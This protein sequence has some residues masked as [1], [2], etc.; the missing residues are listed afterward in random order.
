[1][2]TGVAVAA[3]SAGGA[4]AQTATTQV[5]DNGTAVTEFV[6]TGSRIPE[7]NLTSV[8]PVSV[9]GSDQIQEAGVVRVEDVINQ[10]PQAFAG[11]GSNISNGASGTATVDL[12]GLGCGRTLVLI[13]G[14]RLMPGDP[15]VI[16]AD[17]NFIP[18][19]LIERVDVLTG[20]ASAVY[21][22]DAMA[23]V[24]NFIMRR[25]M[26]GI[27]IDAQVSEYVHTNGDSHIDGIV[28]AERA[29]SANPFEFNL[30]P[31][32]VEDGLAKD[33]TI[34]I[35]ANAPDNKGNVTAYASYRK[36]DPVLQGQRDYS[37]CT[38]GS[39]A[40][41]TCS[42]S[43]TTFPT[44]IGG[45]IVNPVTGNS[46]RAANSVTDVYNF[47]PTNYYQRPD[48]RF[49]IGSFAH[50]EIQ[51]WLTAYTDLM[52]M[53]DRST[54]QI[55]P[56]GYF[57][58]V[59]QINC[60]NP[61]LD[62]TLANSDPALAATLCTPA[63]IANG[64]VIS[65]II[66]RRDVEGG[67]RQTNLEHVQQR[68]VVGLKGDLN[69]VWSYDAYLQYGRTTVNSS[70]TGNFVTTREQNALLVHNVNGVPTCD[71]VVNGSDTKCVPINLFQTG[72]VTQAALNYLSAVS[73]ATGNLG[74]QLANV[75]VTGKLG[76][77]GLKSPWS[78]EGVGINFGAETRSEHLD[79]Q[80]DFLSQ[81]GLVD[82]NGAAALPVN[83][84]YNVNEL[85]AE[86]RVPLV[87]DAPFIKLLDFE[88]GY[89]YSQYSTGQQTSTYKL[90]G[91]F[92]PID[93]IRFRASYQR[94]ARAANVVELYA[95]Q[96]VVLDGTQDP[97][98]G[99]AAGAPNVAK[100]MTAFNYTQAQVLSIQANPANQY[101]G[102]TGGNPNLKPEVGNTFSVGAVVQPRMVP[103]LSVSV[104]YFNIKVNGF[105][106]GIGANLIL[107]T[108]VQTANP[109]F[110]SLVHRDTSQSVASGGFGSLWLSPNG[111]V[112]DTTF[113]TG[114]LQTKGIDFEVNY[115]INLSQ[116]GMGD[117][118]SLAFNGVA[119]DLISLSTSPLPG[120]PAY[121]CEGFYGAT[122]GTPN[123]KWRWKARL[124]WNTPWHGF[125]IS[126]QWRHF[127][128]VTNDCNSSDPQ[129][130][131]CGPAA[132]T[133]ARISSVNYFDLSGSVKI[134]DLVR[135][136]FGVNNIF[137]KDPPLV[138]SSACPVG[139][140]SGNTFA[141]VYDTLGRYMFMGVT[142][143]F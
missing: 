104:D 138:G 58:G 41:Y 136:R 37:E 9:L 133:D 82:G 91:N 34:S 112:Q 4:F 43:S 60:N 36:V 122:C 88:G 51:P 63:Q 134:H 75:N 47:G 101:N 107:N 95:P 66:R 40:D 49:S 14:K 131:G 100:C 68:Y 113:N 132:P 123:P 118:G 85:F 12:R 11:Q 6:V 67:N 59:R 111:F 33:V 87:E 32:H 54:A 115:R 52:F 126:G 3:I 27:R 142:A 13:D 70:Q 56:G 19:S 121:N 140:C 74:E 80:A 109:F 143:D 78:T 116:M 46:F 125:N 98:A 90:A 8:S 73:L 53:D 62:A 76:G 21:G 94:A 42:G 114:Y 97:C 135:L 61:F 15:G 23:G 119:T 35:G 48:E 7:P 84:S 71:S 124:T 120:L 106:G 30:P 86:I 2:I 10:L 102:L 117:H 38:L 141:Q 57:A 69:D 83:N 45:L 28:N 39:G 16:C 65:T 77:Y 81:N 92:E 128:G 108:C 72:G 105:I 18:A 93:G 130:S 79:T 26:E 17:L 64:T 22:S 96:N 129:L 24:V 44:R 1:M 25:D 50:Y 110:C 5:A 127:D 55:A 89:R 20:G 99:L 139:I 29:T 103:G 31:T 137:D